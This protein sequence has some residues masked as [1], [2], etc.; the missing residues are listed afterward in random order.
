[1]N[2]SFYTAID[3]RKVKIL[4]VDQN[5]YKFTENKMTT[6]RKSTALT[7]WTCS[8]PIL[9]S[10]NHR[11]HIMVDMSVSAL[12]AGVYTATLYMMVD[13]VK[14]DG[15]A[16]P[17]SP[18]RADF[19][20]MMEWKEKNRPLPLCVLCGVIV[21]VREVVKYMF[22]K[23]GDQGGHNTNSPNFVPLWELY[24][25]I[26]IFALSFS[27]LKINLLSKLSQQEYIV[28]GM[29]SGIMDKPHILLKGQIVNF[30]L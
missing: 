11:V 14:E 3:L 6:R 13:R 25:F 17:P 18:A 5:K 8:C 28:P 29:G 16:P 2:V 4:Y 24:N 7:L 30:P 9:L 1:M 23:L 20:I 27:F 15:R 21:I 10:V 19:S 26:V 12:S 22:W